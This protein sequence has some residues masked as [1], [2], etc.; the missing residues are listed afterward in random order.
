MAPVD[1]TESKQMNVCRT[2]KA[3][4]ILLALT[5]H[6]FL[7]NGYTFSHRQLTV[8]TYVCQIRSVLDP[9]LFQK[10]IF[11]QAVNR[12]NLRMSLFYDLAPAVLQH[13]DLEALALGLACISLFAMIAGLCALTR[14]FFGSAA[15]GY[16]AVLLYGTALNNWTLGSPAPYLNFF[17]HSLPFSYPLSV[18]S[19]FFFFRR[20]LGRAFFLAG[21]SWNFHPMH[22]AFLLFAYALSFLC[23]YRELRARACLSAAFWFVLPAAP[24]AF[25]MLGHLDSAAGAGQLWLLGA[26]WV[27]WYTCFP[28]TWPVAALIRAFF[29]CGLVV[30]GLYWQGHAALRSRLLPVF[31]SVGILCLAGTIWADYYPV[32]FIIKMSL[33]RSTVIYLF[34][35]LPCIAWLIHR[36]LQKNWLAGAAGTGLVILISG[37]L[38]PLLE[39]EHPA[40]YALPLVLVLLCAALCWAWRRRLVHNPLGC[41]ALLLVLFDC[42]V[43]F[44][45]GGPSIYYHGTIRGHVDPWADVQRVAQRHSSRDDLFIIPPYMNDFSIY[46]L[47]ATTS[48]WAEGSNLIYLDNRFT[49]DWFERMAALGYDREDRFYSGFRTLTTQQILAAARRYGASFVV[50]DKPKTFD[51][52]KI[53]ENEGY[54]LYRVPHGA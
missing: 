47:R 9:D 46:S 30:G 28:S 27:A 25:K 31:L 6:A 53:Y 23:R 33:W 2:L 12:A 19:L 22:T 4:G 20:N 18:W 43:L 42:A 48:D 16:L 32:A 34:L 51:L 7:M 5:A 36:L 49:Q 13:V 50:T 10:S 11:I 40:R 8:G 3:L 54:V 45:Q 15:T 14:L 37:Y 29:F 44:V 39:A 26:R 17:H 38:T 1:R 41:A 21:L 52:P 35:A 24:S